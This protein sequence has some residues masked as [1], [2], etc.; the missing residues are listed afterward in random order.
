MKQRRR[1]RTVASRQSYR[2]RRSGGAGLKRFSGYGLFLTIVIL[3]LAYLFVFSPVFRV[4]TVEVRGTTVLSAGEVADQA[5]QASRTELSGVSVSSLVLADAGRITTA[6]TDRYSAISS[7]NMHKK[8]PSKLI[9]EIQERQHAVVW[10]TRENLYLVDAN[11][12]A[13]A[14]T[15]PRPD[16]TVIEDL[17]GLPAEVGKP[18]AGGS[19]IRTVAEIRRGLEAG[20]VRTPTFRVPETTFEVQAVAAEGYYVLF[21]TT[22][23]VGSQI[24]AALEAIKQGRPGQYAD[25]R[26]PGRVYVM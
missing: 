4:S 24:Q 16:V 10:K 5:K 6:L 3:A 11:G 15:S 23:P 19:F 20:G 14:S 22:R 7:V 2:P 25:V 12:V 1:R 17:T 8:W 13:F 9:I 18:V 21:D 26:V